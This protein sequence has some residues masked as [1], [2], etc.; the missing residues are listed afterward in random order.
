MFGMGSLSLMDIT[1]LEEVQGWAVKM[2]IREREKT[3]RVQSGWTEESSALE[4]GWLSRSV[5]NIDTAMN[6]VDEEWLFKFFFI[7]DLEV[8]DEVW[9]L[10]RRYF[11]LQAGSKLWKSSP[12][13]GCEKLMWVWKCAGGICGRHRARLLKNMTQEIPRHN[14]CRWLIILGRLIVLWAVL[15]FLRPSSGCWQSTQRGA[16]SDWISVMPHF[17][18][19]RRHRG[20]WEHL[21]GWAEP[22]CSPWTTLLSRGSWT[23]EKEAVQKVD[24]DWILYFFFCCCCWLFGSFWRMPRSSCPSFS[25]S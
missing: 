19:G 14:L 23:G 7:P 13:G 6:K 12:L 18:L 25:A 17:F 11:F 24:L 22:S 20:S 1:K 8:A 9:R 5:I 21:A 4:K 3:F 10:K 2:V 15:I 16:C